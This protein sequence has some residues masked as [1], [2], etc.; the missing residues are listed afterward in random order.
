M[1]HE[2][3]IQPIEPEYRG[4]SLCFPRSGWILLGVMP[5]IAVAIG[6]GIGMPIYQEQRAILDAKRLGWLIR[7]ESRVPEWISR[8]FEVRSLP[9]VY[10]ATSAKIFRLRSVPVDHSNSGG[11]IGPFDPLSRMPGLKA[12]DF[13]WESCTDADLLPL[14][15]LH[16][17]ESLKLGNGI[18]DDGLA[19]IAGMTRL[20]TLDLTGTDI[21]EAG[22]AHICQM[23]R[24]RTLGL[25]PIDVSDKGIGHLARLTEL[26]D[27]EVRGYEITDAGLAQ[28]ANLKHLTRLRLVG[29]PVTDEGMKHL[30]GLA[31]LE[32]LHLSFTEVGDR[33]LAHL[34]KLQSLRLLTLSHTRVTDAGLLTL[35]DCAG[36]ELIFVENTRITDA[37]IAELRM[38]RPSIA[39]ER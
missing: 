3:R 25:P 1:S 37:G 18:T 30:S 19:H 5:L 6:M 26:R 15:K 29:S 16:E 35:R 38:A 31:E 2:A 14:S 20:E 12:I 4:L 17:L 11:S 21:S 39:V 7:T 9:E 32:N 34:S 33:G 23:N 27:F 10:E 24:L 22:L 36:L 28:L 13:R 8:W